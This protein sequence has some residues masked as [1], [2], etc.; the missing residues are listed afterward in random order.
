LNRP[1]CLCGYKNTK[2]G[3]GQTMTEQDFLNTLRYCRLEDIM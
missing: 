1:K 2:K 3:L